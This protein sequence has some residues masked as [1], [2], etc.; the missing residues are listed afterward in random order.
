[1]RISGRLRLI[2]AT[3]L[4]GIVLAVGA[5][6]YQMRH[7]LLDDREVK[8]RHIVE[9]GTSMLAWFEDQ[10]RAGRMTRDEAQAAALSA[11]DRLRYQDSEYLWVHR[12]ADSAMLAHPNRK[13]VGQSVDDMKD[14][15]GLFVF[16]EMNRI[17]RESKAGFQ[18]Y[19]WPK[20]GASEPVSKLSY[21]QGFA[22]W[23]WVIGSG[24]YVDDV[25]ATFRSRSL[26]FSAAAVIILG[27]AWAIAAWVGR[28]ITGQLGDVTSALA[29]LTNDEH[30]VEIRHAERVDEIGE[31]ARGLLVFRGHI[32]QA[33]QAAAEKLRQQDAN[34]ARQRRIEG[35][36]RNF[37]HKVA[38]V[39]KSV[40]AA[41]SQMQAT[42]Q[43]MSAIAE[44]TARQSTAV[45]EAAGH[46]AMSV[47]TVAAATE[48]LHASEAE[49][50]RQVE[51]SSERA[52]TAVAEA[53]R[54]STIVNGLNQAA[55]RIGEVVSLI[56]DIASQTNLLAL[57]AT[58]EAARAG[59]AGKGF[60]VVAGE[61]KTLAN[62]TAKATEEI[63]S[64]ILGVQAAANDAAEAIRA[65]ARSI[66]E[67]DESSAAVALAVDQQSAA[68][69]E[70]A[71]NIEQAASGTGEVSA[72]ITEVSHAA[73]VAGTTAADVLAAATE[74]ARQA[75]ALGDE[76]KGFL[77][78]LDDDGERL[79]PVLTLVAA[80]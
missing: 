45:A 37:D 52:R 47:Q 54:G 76:V 3:A 1:M 65:I 68:T 79:P 10:E 36:A 48:E 17:V 22:P 7:D 69:S 60:A 78:S 28:G 55:G 75:D 72:N 40:S 23:G 16:R 67:I 19:M 4:C 51:A 71:R 56:N 66:G 30:D 44:Q 35:L 39:I 24:I 15:N 33:Q 9:V 74:L 26:A 6:L 20:P 64:Q 12:L 57:N 11:I 59:E 32:E 58:I 27:L 21:V 41:S 8:T 31:L 34:L 46:A 50:A 14:P 38:G 18:Y 42:S 43:S 77:S 53:E 2:V 25:D 61:V 73:G 63:S 62:Q 80:E 5:S 13:L 29:R 70:I 49:I